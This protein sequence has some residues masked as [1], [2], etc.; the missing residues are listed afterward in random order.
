[1]TSG[2]REQAKASV[3][4]K[5]TGKEWREK[6]EITDMTLY[7]KNGTLLSLQP[8]CVLPR[9]VSENSGM[10]GFSYPDVF[11][12]HYS[13]TNL[14]PFFC[15]MFLMASFVVLTSL[16]SL[17]FLI[18]AMDQ[19]FSS[20]FYLYSQKYLMPSLSRHPQQFCPLS[21][22]QSLCTVVHQLLPLF[23]S[24][25]YCLRHLGGFCLGQGYL[26]GASRGRLGLH[27]MQLLHSVIASLFHF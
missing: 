6:G 15:F 24:D 11:E 10:R 7:L 2:A 16:T 19:L 20:L 1:M 14:L 27:V 25:F 22:L 17:H 3:W 13:F 21:N 5:D 4:S 12:L 9:R 8:A 18:L 26:T 23:L